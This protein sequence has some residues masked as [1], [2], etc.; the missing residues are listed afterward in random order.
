MQ[1]EEITNR[2][3]AIEVF[4]QA[5]GLAEIKPN[6]MLDIFVPYRETR[7]GGDVMVYPM[8]M[9]R[10]VEI[11]PEALQLLDDVAGWLH[12]QPEISRVYSREDLPPKLWNAVA[13]TVSNSIIPLETRFLELK[14]KLRETKPVLTVA[15]IEGVAIDDQIIDL[16]TISIGR[17]GPAFEEFLAAQCREKGLPA[18]QFSDEVVWT[19]EY[20]AWRSDVSIREEGP[21]RN[22]PVV[23]AVWTS[24]QGMKSFDVAHEKLELLFA[25]FHYFATMD[26]IEEFA[27]PHIM[28]VNE[29]VQK[30]QER[31]GQATTDDE[32]PD[33]DECQ[34]LRVSEGSWRPLKVG[35]YE[36]EDKPID[37]NALFS[38]AGKLELATRLL[39]TLEKQGKDWEHRFARHVQWCHIAATAT[40]AATAITAYSIALEALVTPSQPSDSLTQLIAERVAFLEPTGTPEQRLA[41]TREVKQFYNERSKL[42]HGQRLILAWGGEDSDYVG[43]ASE[44]AR[45][46]GKNFLTFAQVVQWEVEAAMNDWY[47][48]RRFYVPE[49]V[50]GAE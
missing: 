41:K 16:G 20:V 18:F 10:L 34:F 49:P 25:V 3:K 48:Q 45:S 26:G 24:E 1:R 9:G 43:K 15:P 2:N 42:V 13:E 22:T 30:F 50:A 5:V 32:D 21:L 47:D 19:E 31:I 37:L 28:K 27:A 8:R 36:L 38:D 7:E 35:Y 4:K 12:R 46:V 14:N 33:Y 11:P 44:M 39:D 23:A 29:Y 17:V 6:P 40:G